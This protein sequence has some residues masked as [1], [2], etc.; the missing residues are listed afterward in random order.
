[1]V[2]LEAVSSPSKSVRQS[3]SLPARTARR[4]KA[5]ARARKASANR[6][7]VELVETGLESMEDEKRRFAILVDTLAATKDATERTRLKNELAR[8]TFGE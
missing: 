3:I 2:Y 1:M 7:L 5:L 8:L 6:V 4:V